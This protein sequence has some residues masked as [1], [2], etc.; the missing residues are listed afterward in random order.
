MPPDRHLITAPRHRRPKCQPGFGPIASTKPGSLIWINDVCRGVRP[1][2]RTGCVEGRLW[3]ESGG[4]ASLTI[5]CASVSPNVRCV[6]TIVRRSPASVSANVR[7][8]PRS[9]ARRAV[10]H[11]APLH[12]GDVRA[13]AGLCQQPTSFPQA[14][15]QQSS[16][17]P[18]G[19]LV[20]FAFD[21]LFI[22]GADI[23]DRP[24]LK[25]KARL[26]RIL[27]G[28]PSATVQA[29]PLTD[30]PRRLTA[31]PAP[32]RCGARRDR[33]RVRPS[34]RRRAARRSRRGDG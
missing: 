8:K 14:S 30:M 24:L 20:Y 5:Y 1:A 21:M 27:A 10:H 25:R 19:R 2:P 15:G 9:I 6:S 29:I 32:C 31:A 28:A 22:N 12:I 3:V 16:A 18:G 17:D 4:R 26:E 13:T 11:C 7:R 23:A 33:R 34:G